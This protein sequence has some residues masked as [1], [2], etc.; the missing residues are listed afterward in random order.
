MM[1][2]QDKKTR[3][4][5]CCLSFSCW[6]FSLGTWLSLTLLIINVITNKNELLV[7]Y[8]GALRSVT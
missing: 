7:P 4:G 8:G 5:N 2:L 3:S 6:L 1:L